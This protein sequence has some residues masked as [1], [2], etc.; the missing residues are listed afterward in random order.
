MNKLPNEVNTNPCI[1]YFDS[2]GLLDKKYSNMIR[3]YLQKEYDEKKKQ[4]VGI[5]ITFDEHTLPSI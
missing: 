3:L 4:E 2:F 5:D 1:L